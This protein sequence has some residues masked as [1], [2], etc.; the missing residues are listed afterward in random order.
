MLEYKSP[1][2]HD[3][4]PI[5]TILVEDPDPAGP[6][7][8]KEVG[9]GPLLPVMP[10]V[11]NAVYDAV[12]VRIRETPVTPDKILKALDELAKGGTGVYAPAAFPEIPWPEPLWVPPPWEGGDG[13]AVNDP[14]RRRAAKLEKGNP[15]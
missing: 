11:V 13:N 2:I 3:T 7:G 5:E 8:A 14:E 6:F 15:S 4:P 10:A 1:T 9:Q 12:G